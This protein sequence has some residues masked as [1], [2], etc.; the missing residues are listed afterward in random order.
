MLGFF[1]RFQKGI[2]IAITTVIVISFSFFG[3]FSAIERGNQD[4]VVFTA[5]DGSSVKKSEVEALGAFLSSDSV[6]QLNWGAVLGANFLNDGVIRNDFL[7][8]GLGQALFEEYY[9]ELKEEWDGKWKRE[10]G[11]QAYKHPEVPYFSADAVWTHF[12]P[13]LKS[14]LKTYKAGNFEGAADQFEKKAD[15]YLAEGEFSEGKLRQVLYYQLQQA[16]WIKPDRDLQQQYL[17]L[18]GYRNVNDWFGHDFVRL[19][20]SFIINASKIAEKKGYVVTIEEAVYDLKKNAMV[21][22]EIQKQNPQMTIQDPSQYLREQLR[23]LGMDLGKA[24]EVWQRVL[25]FRKMFQ[26]LG[27]AV[28]VDRVTFEPV[29]QAV[30]TQ[31]EG[32]VYTLPKEAQIRDF[33]QFQR[34]HTYM[35]KM[36]KDEALL[37]KNYLVDLKEVDHTVAST[38]ISLKEIW[39]W[40]VSDAGWE[41]LQAQFSE[42]PSAPTAEERFAALDQLDDFTKQMIDAKTRGFLSKEHPEWIDESFNAA[43]V[44]RKTLTF[45][46]VGGKS[47]LRGLHDTAPAVEALDK[48][49]HVI[50]RSGDKSWQVT[51]L[52][53]SPDWEVA[54]YAEA[55]RD[56]ILEDL[57]LA[58]LEATAENRDEIAQETFRRE[59]NK[60]RRSMPE[61]SSSVDLISSYTFFDH[62][63]G[64]RG[65]DES[66][67]VRPAA[68]AVADRLPPRVA[69]EDQFKL[70]KQEITWDRTQNQPEIPFE[71]LLALEPNQLSDLVHKP[72]GELFFYKVVG[73]H[74]DQEDTLLQAMMEKS[75]RHLSGA[76]QSQLAKELL[77]EIKLKGSRAAV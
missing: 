28:V 13:G 64:L 9:D 5:V 17:G 59:L 16:K 1:R 23:Y 10:K 44:Q 37:L 4:L 8:S 67:A 20:S 2:F 65:S 61:T 27:S 62:V 73:N 47:P 31:V 11:Y 63:N 56:G 12:A 30:A 33:R 45:Y 75:Q 46:K 49:S 76:L 34:L 29:V 71:L 26:D 70:V 6:D 35:H 68:A 43:P 69:L 41:K 48:E 38:N 42:L 22:F 54:T 60:A 15:L 58:Y 19:V 39:D 57:T 14:A 21:A 18:F 32:V 74:T 55:E 24:A 7:K 77:K 3:T 40:Q 50:L 66:V 36:G 25:L 72:N 52:D 53:R 51:V